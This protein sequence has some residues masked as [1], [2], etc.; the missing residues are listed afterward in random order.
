VLARYTGGATGKPP[1]VLS[2]SSGYVSS[3]YSANA[4]G[5]VVWLGD[6]GQGYG[7]YLWPPGDS[8]PRLVLA[9]FAP[10]PTGEPVA[11]FYSGAVDANGTVYACVRGVETAWMLLRL[12]TSPLLI[13]ANGTQLS[14][15][16][17][18]DLY[19]NLVPG[20]RSGPLHIMA[21]GNQQSILQ[22][23][24][25]GLLP[26][27]LVG[28]G[29]PGGAIYTGN[30]F[31]RKSPSGVLYVT[32]DNGV[33]RIS[34][35]GPS[36]LAAYPFP[37]ADGVNVSSPFNL[38]VNDSNQFLAI[39]GTNANHQR[40][41]LF[42]GKTL[43]SL[44][45]F[46]G[47]PPFQTQSPSGG[48]FQNINE[49]ALAESGQPMIIATVAGGPSGLFVFDDGVWKTVCALQSCK[50]DGE[51]VTSIGQLHASNNRFCAFFNTSAGNN[52]IDCWESGVWTNLLKRGE[53][54]SDG[55]EIGN[56]NS[57]F[58]INRGGDLA[59]SLNTGL[60]GQSVFLKTA[61]GY[62]T[63]QSSAFPFADGS[64][65][66][67]LYAI[68]L[69]DDRRVFFLVMDNNSRMVVYEADPQQ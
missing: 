48:V 69:R 63:V 20:D 62:S 3:L 31:P 35:S 4:R 24:D 27:L 13:A 45:Y 14:T 1:A 66:S 15:T 26:T 46:N 34:D 17:N 55:T 7:L 47:G 8:I 43:R 68:D 21:G 12:N 38:A 29:L 41:T 64:Y 51:T 36:L 28:D 37:M 16:A 56:V 11:D 33:F 67:G 53:F 5:G 32:T 52:R 61:D 10:S 44:G 65:I 23:N 50:F 58:D 60:T 22:P 6:Y 2:A 18:L 19:S 25:R 30:N 59:V 39:G 49:L 42:D 9:R 40:L 57:L 54:T